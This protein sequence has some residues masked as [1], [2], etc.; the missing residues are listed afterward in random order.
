MHIV[1]KYT[2]VETPLDVLPR[3]SNNLTV[4]RYIT[5]QSATHSVNRRGVSPL[6]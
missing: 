4:K 1:I 6:L 5:L 3:S 2:F